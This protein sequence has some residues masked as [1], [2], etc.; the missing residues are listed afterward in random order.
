MSMSISGSVLSAVQA[1]G[2]MFGGYGTLTIGP[3]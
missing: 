1:V 3:V 2:Q